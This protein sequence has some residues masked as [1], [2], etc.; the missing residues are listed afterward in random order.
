MEAESKVE[1]KS[2]LELTKTGGS[3]TLIFGVLGAGVASVSL[4]SL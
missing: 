1:N 2:G 4:F 3:G